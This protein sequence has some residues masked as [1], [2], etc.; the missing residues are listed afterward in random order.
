[1]F[2]LIIEKTDNIEEDSHE[3]CCIRPYGSKLGKAYDTISVC[4]I[5]VHILV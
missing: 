5:G 1:M 2:V 4:D 3:N